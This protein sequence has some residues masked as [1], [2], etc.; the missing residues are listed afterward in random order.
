MHC[1][2]EAF[3]SCLLR[4]VLPAF[5]CRVACRVLSVINSHDVVVRCCIVHRPTDAPAGLATTSHERASGSSR[6]SSGSSPSV[7]KPKKH[8][9][10]RPIV[11][12][13]P[14]STNAMVATIPISHW[15]PIRHRCFRP[16]VRT[17]RTVSTPTD[18]PTRPC[19]GCGYRALKVRLH[20]AYAVSLAAPAQPAH[21]AVQCSA[22]QH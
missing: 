18:R 5:P 20:R 14:F 8:T 1:P 10:V 4:S 19:G 13:P 12:L 2:T 9:V 16:T 11:L 22:V 7:A 3:V 17:E 15:K 6:S 21:S